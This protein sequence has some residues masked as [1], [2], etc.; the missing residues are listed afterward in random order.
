M[1]HNLISTVA[2]VCCWTCLI[3][4]PHRHL[5]RQ[6]CPNRGRPPSQCR[7][8]LA[9]N[10]GCIAAPGMSRRRFQSCSV[11]FC[12]GNRH[13]DLPSAQRVQFLIGAMVI[14][15]LS[16]CLSSSLLFFI[17]HV[18]HAHC[19]SRNPCQSPCAPITSTISSM[20]IPTSMST[21]AG[22]TGLTGTSVVADISKLV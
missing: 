10:I 15:A 2:A 12:R 18:D 13:R 16:L 6:Q 19:C 11:S 20:S 9:H 7:W 17:P 4:E 3:L 1:R 5:H 22:V 8:L 21:I 14:L